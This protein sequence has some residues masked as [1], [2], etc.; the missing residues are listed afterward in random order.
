[1]NCGGSLGS[2]VHDTSQSCPSQ[3]MTCRFLTPIALLHARNCRYVAP[4]LAA[5]RWGGTDVFRDDEALL[6]LTVLPADVPTALLGF[7]ATW[8][9]RSV[10][11][12]IRVHFRS[13][14]SPWV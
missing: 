7:P 8:L 13:P 9:L 1:M 2:P 6:K 11:D 14:L 3:A 5:A 12:R 10:N 4:L